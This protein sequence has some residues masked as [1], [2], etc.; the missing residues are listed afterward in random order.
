M[1][2]AENIRYLRK[3]HALSQG[4]LAQELGYKSFTTIQK[5]ESGIAEPPLSVLGRM[6]EL[7]HVDLADLANTPLEQKRPQQGTGKSLRIPVLGKVAAGIPMEAVENIIDYEEI[8]AVGKEPEEYFGLQIKG[9]SMFPRIQE[10]D[11][12]IVRKQA[13]VDSGDTAIVMVN[14]ADA[15]CKKIKKNDAGI[16]LIPLNSKYEPTFFSNEEIASL[17]V[18][19]IGKVVEL[20]G[21]L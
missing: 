12:V 7:F 20:R 8:A 14:G 17:P 19:I 9:D 11:V 6:S 16:L 13:D 3:K 1:F 5:W 18:T 15:T 21:K 4:D 2:L 10:G